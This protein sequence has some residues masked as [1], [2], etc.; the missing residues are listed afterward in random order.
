MGLDN[1]NILY[2]GTENHIFAAQLND[3]VAVDAG[4]IN[5]EDDEEA[6][7][8]KLELGKDTRKGK[9]DMLEKDFRLL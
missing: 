1:Q 3:L 6:M 7:Y 5:F 9:L 8:Q 4:I 2:V